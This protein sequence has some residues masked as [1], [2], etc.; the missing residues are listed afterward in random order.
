MMMNLR[1]ENLQEIRSESENKCARPA[2]TTRSFFLC[3]VAL[4]REQGGTRS[5]GVN[6]MNTPYAA[7]LGLHSP[8]Q[9][10]SVSIAVAEEEEWV[11]RCGGMGSWGARRDKTVPVALSQPSCML[12][13]ACDVAASS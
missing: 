5:L 6:S 3:F 1:R 7:L 10:E 13:V 2:S 11:R 9:V 8:G 4:E 12:D